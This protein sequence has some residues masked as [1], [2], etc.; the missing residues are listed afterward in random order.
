MTIRTRSR[1]S[2]TT[3][4]AWFRRQR[5]G[6]DG[7]GPVADRARRRSVASTRAARDHEPAPTDRRA[8]RVPPPARRSRFDL[9]P[10][11]P[12]ERDGCGP[13]VV[14]HVHLTDQTLI[15]QHGVVRTEHGPITLDQFRQLADPGRPDDHDPTRPRPGRDRGGR[16]LR[17]PPTPPAGHD[18]PPSRIG[19]AVQP[20]HH[21]Q[22]RWPARPGPHHPPHHERSTRPNRH[23]QPRTADPDR[24]PRQDPRRL[25]GPTTRPRHLPVAITRRTRSRSPPTKAPSCSATATG[26]TRS[27]PPRARVAPRPED[28]IGLESDELTRPFQDQRGISSPS[29]TSSADAWKRYIVV[30]VAHAK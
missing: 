13:R 21:H 23:G 27:G 28:L 24:A 20:R 26:P 2:T 5:D 15:E 30:Q 19:V 7:A 25:A 29:G 12:T 9:R 6:D 22:H 10:F 3:D 18:R 1:R 14:I 4:L 11:T 17:D 8:G 16:R